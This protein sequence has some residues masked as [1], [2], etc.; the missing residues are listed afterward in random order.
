M[1]VFGFGL[2][3]GVSAALALGALSPAAQA[4]LY[5]GKLP[6]AGAPASPDDPAVVIPLVGATPQEAR[7]NLIWTMRAG[8]NVAALQCGFAPQLRTTSNYNNLLHQHA[9]ELQA[10]YA[11][12]GAYFKRTQPKIWDT[13]L[14]QY[15]TRTYNSFSTLQAQLG[16]CEVAAAIGRD[17]LERPRGQLGALAIE[18]LREFRNSLTPIRDTALNGVRTALDVTAPSDLADLPCYDK[19]GRIIVCKPDKKKRD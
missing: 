19:K 5:W 1:A 16:F 9:T 2:R 18:R 10:S 17:T 3:M 15:V 13:A 14:D 6:V 11:A 7:A 12:L 8:L 4:Y